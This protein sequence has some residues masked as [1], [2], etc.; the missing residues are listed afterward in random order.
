MFKEIW[1]NYYRYFKVSRNESKLAILFGILGASLETF[2]IYLLASIIT[3]LGYKNNLDNIRFLEF[4]NMNYGIYFIFI[5]S[6]TF[7]AYLYYISNKN[8]IKAK[9]IVERFIRQEITDLTIKI[10]WEYY[11][12]L[13]QGDISKSII[14][15]GQNISEGYMYFLQSIT[16]S[17][18]ASTYFIACL[19]FVPKTL[20]ILIIYALLT[21]RIY[22]HYSK[23]SDKYGKNLSKITS[24]I[25][26]WTSGIFNNLKYLRAISKDELAKDESK[27]IFL[28][29]SNSYENS[30][31]AS[32]KSRFITELLTIVFISL[33]I[34]YITL[35]GGDTS[36]LILSLSLFIRMTPKV[37]NAQS[38]LLDSVSMVSWP[39]L[40]HEKVYWAKK[41]I[42]KDNK[43]YKYFKF[44]GKIVF[45][46]VFFNYPDNKKILNNINVE[47][48]PRECIGI[49]GK[50]GSGKST[51]LDLITGILKPDKGDILLS[52]KNIKNID[53]NSWRNKI[54]IVMQENFFK[55]DT[56]ASNITLGDKIDIDRIRKSLINANAWDFVNDLPNGIDEYI[57]DR[58]SRFSGGERQRLA[59]AR[60]LY[61]NPQIL[62]LDEPS[63]GLD[64]NSEKKLISSIQKIKGEMII[65]IVSHKKEVLSICDRILKLDKNGLK[66]I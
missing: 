49:N 47:F 15:E 36:Y 16:F 14:S 34:T 17:F 59:L 28:K 18:V 6:A 3:N 19:I 63:T 46:S 25:G 38:R 12:R 23:E 30:R 48:Q 31:V 40:H 57:Y 65:I 22:M 60:A 13:S 27:K 50:S 5:L 8:I 26:K 33:S 51:I 56:I 21:F 24:N 1:K 64:R 41:F 66:Q 44:N 4:N 7:S 62:L 39:K 45:K 37:Y 52:G 35:T 53:I 10:K 20:F 43:N 2:S 9:C 42:N 54:G 55:N 11:Q 58:G 61:S 29:F 32:Y